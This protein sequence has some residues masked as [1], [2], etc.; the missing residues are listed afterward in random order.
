MKTE[1]PRAGN[2]RREMK[3]AESAPSSVKE[4]KPR[5]AT[6]SSSER[7]L[8]QKRKSC[9]AVA[10]AEENKLNQA[11][12]KTRPSS[13]HEPCSRP[14]EK[15]K[16]NWLKDRRT[17]YLATAENSQAEEKWIWSGNKNDIK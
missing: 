2:N 10:A 3:I 8:E 13:A 14:R 1:D 4:P 16:P 9:P 17:S 15:S 5:S 6:I 12:K 11:E 7:K